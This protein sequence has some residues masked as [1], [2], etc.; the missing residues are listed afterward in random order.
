MSSAFYPG[1]GLDIVPPILFRHIK[2]WFYMDSQ[3]RSEFGHICSNRVERPY[4]IRKLY[5]IMKQNNFHTISVTENVHSFYNSEHDQTIHYE[6]NSVF[7]D[8]LQARHRVCDTLVSCGY[9]MTG[10]PDN[11][12]ASFSS[13]ITNTRTN[14]EI[15]DETILLGKKVDTIVFDPEWEYWEE[16]EQ[17]TPIIQRYTS[18]VPRFMTYDERHPNE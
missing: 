1:S 5:T 6:T 16:H 2:T 12:I 17:F 18:I 9:K 15:D 4:F 13:I 10:K 11:F 14:H 7:P 8:A 3:P